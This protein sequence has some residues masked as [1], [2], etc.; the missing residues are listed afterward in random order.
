MGGGVGGWLDQVV[1]KVSQLSTEL[2]LK[3]K[4][5]LAKICAVKM[6]LGNKIGVQKMCE[7]MVVQKQYVGKNNCFR[8]VGP[9]KFWIQ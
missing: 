5:G 3:L 7:K 2:K 1:I 9:N 6:D 4:L 8:N